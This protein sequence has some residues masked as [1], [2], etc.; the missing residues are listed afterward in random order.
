LKKIHIRPSLLKIGLLFCVFSL[1]P[2]NSFAKAA[3]TE[4]I[5]QQDQM[6]AA[7][8]TNWCPADWEH[9][10]NVHSL[11]VQLT[12]NN[13]DQNNC[14]KNL[15][16]WVCENITYDWK[17][18]ECGTYS[19]LLP[20]Q[21]L[22]ERKAVCEGIANLTQALF[23]EAGIPCIKVWG[24]ALE[25]EN[26][27]EKNT[28]VN[29]ERVNHTWNEFYQAGR[30]ITVDCTM[31]ILYGTS[32]YFDPDETAFARTHHRL[33]RGDDLPEDIPSAW[34]IPEIAEA[35][36]ESLVPL[37]WLSDYHTTITEAEWFS[38]TGLGRGR[39]IPLTRLNA[40]MSLAPMIDL[41]GSKNPPYDDT[42]SCSVKEKQVLTVLW[43]CGV[44][45]GCNGRFFP[46]SLLTR[47]AAIAV[48]VR[49][50]RMGV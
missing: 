15:Y 32:D 25:P 4:W 5:F 13:Q 29:P 35:V 36:N 1:L 14:P 46:D 30:W 6:I 37:A 31:G 43:H 34:A 24:A 48:W 11:A 40:A 2:A 17:A 9:N 3:K 12:K 28:E 50:H 26:C 10:E 33:R 8:W 19:A 45:T 16:E 42:A 20:S 21:V 49:L 44:M 38:L 18:Q 47:Q 22:E 27:W 23:L 39:N 41:S 7:Q